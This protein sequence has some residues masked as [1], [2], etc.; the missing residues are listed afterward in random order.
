MPNHFMQGFLVDRCGITGNKKA[1]AISI[2]S[3][4]LD[5]IVMCVF[6]GELR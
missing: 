6:M 1:L 2:E 3:T 4:L 5:T